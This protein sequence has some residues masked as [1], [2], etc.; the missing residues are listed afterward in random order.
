MNVQPMELTV[1]NIVR[2]VLFIIREEFASSSSA[3][4]TQERSSASPMRDPVSLQP[5]LNTILTRGSADVD[6]TTP[7]KSLMSNIMAQLGELVDELMNSDGFIMD[8]AVNHIS[9]NSIILTFGDSSTVEKFLTSKKMKR[10]FQVFVAES[11]PSCGGHRLARAL[12]EAGVDTTV[13]ADAA[14]FALMPRVDKVV[15]PTQAVMANGGLVTPSGGHMLALAAKEH[16]V[17]VVC[18][19]GLYKLCP[20]YPH[21]LQAEFNELQ[22]PA[23]VLAGRPGGKMPNVDIINPAFDYVPPELV[24]LYVTNTGGHQPSYIYRLL[25]EY[26]HPDDQLPY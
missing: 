21:D 18:V 23:V 7:V 1:G 5:S 14:V 6:Y 26:Y 11:A 9:D 22:S 13:I 2:R 10:H 20:L 4:P 3:E 12:A 8:Q 25:A 15:L 19:T 24:D 16:A 17:P